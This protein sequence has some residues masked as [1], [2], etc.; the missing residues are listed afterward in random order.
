MCDN[1]KLNL[2]NINAYITIGEILPFVLKISNVNEI[3]PLIKVHNSCSNVRKMTCNNS[4]L[5][6]VKMNTYIKGVRAL[7]G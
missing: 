7:R 3:L 2:V 4:N 5:D 1:P 6:L